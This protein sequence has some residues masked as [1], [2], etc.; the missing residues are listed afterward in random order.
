[1]QDI[2]GDGV[3]HIDFAPYERPGHERDALYD[4]SKV[5]EEL[6]FAPK[7]NILTAYKQ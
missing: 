7:V 3:A 6:G 1:M 4:N 5:R 2:Y